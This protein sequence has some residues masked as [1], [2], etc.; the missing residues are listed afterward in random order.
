[1]TNR[2]E[3]TKYVNGRD[4]TEIAKL[5]RAEIKTAIKDGSLPEGLKASVRISR[6]SMGQSLDIG[7]TS[8]GGISPFNPEWVAWKMDYNGRNVYRPCTVKRYT[9]LAQ[10]VLDKLTAIVKQYNM[11]LSDDFNGTYCVNFHSSI[12]YNID[13]KVQADH[14]RTPRRVG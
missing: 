6:Y 12:R 3:G 7:I 14:V 9:G 4:I 11:S 5:V 10:G 2:F 1:M 8:L 13:H